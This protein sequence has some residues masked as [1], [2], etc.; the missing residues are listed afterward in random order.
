MPLA[1]RKQPPIPRSGPARAAWLE[2]VYAR[3]HDPRFIG[4]D[5]LQVL[6]RYGSPS[7]REIAGLVAAC[8]A[9]GNVK[10]IM[11][12]IENV[13]RRMTPS[14]R[15]YLLDTSPAAIAAD[16]KNFRYR[17]TSPTDMTNLLLGVKNILESRGSLNACFIA[18]N[19][20]RA[21]SLNGDDPH[22]DAIAAFV[23]ALADAS[24]GPLRHLVPHPSRG[25][26]CKRLM[27]YF[28]W[29]VRRDSIDPG[30]WIGLDPAS[31]IIPLDTHVHR[32]SLRLNLT[33]RKQPNLATALEITRRLRAI[34]P[35]DPLRYDFSLT[36]PGI[37]RVPAG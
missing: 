36:R 23:D 37:M 20:G 25:S 8:L 14:P 21:R 12:G 29:M 7:E 5:P 11:G 24:G 6:Y 33:R 32:M 9:Y 2:S 26:A 19:T 17:V 35:A 30:G 22:L 15:V 10:A 34:C 3:F 16:F 31:L 28:R 27:L 4:T 18:G 1:P 13:L